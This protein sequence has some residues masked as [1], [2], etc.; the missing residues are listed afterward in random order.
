MPQIIEVPN[1]GQVEFPDGMTDEQIV[2]AIKKNALGYKREPVETFDPAEG[3]GT[4]QKFLAGAGKGMTDLYQGAKQVMGFASDADVQEKRRLDSALMGTT[5]G[6]IGNFIGQ[7]AALAPAVLV[8]GANTYAG[9]SV[10]GALSGALNPTVEGE[11]RGTNMALGAAGGVAGQK[12]GSMLS[13][14]IGKNVTAAANQRMANATRDAT[15]DELQQAG[16]KIPRSLYDPRFLSNRLESIAGK[17]AVKQNAALAGQ[18]TTNALARRYLGL[19]DD[20]PID[21]AL[22]ESL[23]K[24]ASGPYQEASKLSS[25]YRPGV[26]S[27]SSKNGAQ[28]VEAIKLARDDSRAAW[29]TLNSGNAQNPTELRQVATSADSLAASLEMQ[30]DELATKSGNPDLVNALRAARKNIAKVHSIDNALNDAT[31]DVSARKLAA[32]LKRNVPLDKE[33]LTIAKFADAFPQI[34]QDGAKVPAAG[35]SKVEAL[36]A[37]L[38]AGG[39]GAA[40]GPP[41][42]S[43][44]ALTALP[45]MVRPFVLSGGVP[46]YGSN[47]A[48]LAAKRIPYVDATISD[49]LPYFGLLGGATAAQ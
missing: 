44:A 12:V 1:Y 3:M 33:A 45:H 20:T 11:S 2:A 7:T 48:A 30:L 16:Y 18:Q 46:K 36:M 40:F 8:P 23:R 5:G 17:A 15:I 42:I 26:N 22:M 32:Q 39:G 6:K 28:L 10:I 21:D 19:A 49:M 43:A 27:A 13:N 24:S 31:G 41:G 38:L 9:A 37:T 47:A 35:V 14:A 34:A 4:T 29:R 25:L